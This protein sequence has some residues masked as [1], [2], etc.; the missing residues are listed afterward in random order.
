LSYICSVMSL[1]ATIKMNKL[2]RQILISGLLT[3]VVTIGFASKGGGGDK[4]DVASLKNN[5]TPIRTINGFTLKTTRPV[6]SGSMLLGQAK[7]SNR[8]SLNAMI[9]YQQGN[10]TYILPYKYKLAASSLINSKS[11]LQLVGV[12]IKMPK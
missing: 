5:F 11:N 1:V 9:T 12:K 7:E 8:L 4:K 10:V 3:A 6:Y 2:I